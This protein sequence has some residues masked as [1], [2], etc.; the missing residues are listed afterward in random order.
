MTDE[1]KK[2]NNRVDRSANGAFIAFWHGQVVYENGRVKKFKSEPDAW[3]YLTR[4]D[5]AG[6]IIH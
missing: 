3:Q 4:C 1:T 6:K 2:P 5:A